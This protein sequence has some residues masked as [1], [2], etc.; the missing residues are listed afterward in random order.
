[1]TKDERLRFHEMQA[2]WW[3]HSASN[4][5]A[6]CRNIEHGDGRP[7]TVEELRDNAMETSQQ[8]MR[9]FLEVAENWKEASDD[10]GTTEAHADA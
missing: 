8:H 3:M 10:K 6:S 2:N 7:F 5:H 4:G 9:L 1:M